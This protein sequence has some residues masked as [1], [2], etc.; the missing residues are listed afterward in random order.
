MKAGFLHLRITTRLTELWPLGHLL[1]PA[2]LNSP[3]DDLHDPTLST[4]SFRRLLKTQLF[5]E[6]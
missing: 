1:L 2:Q 5:S 4:D 6:Y 3:S